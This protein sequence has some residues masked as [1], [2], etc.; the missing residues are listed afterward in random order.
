MTGE[1]TLL[2]KVLPIGGLKEKVLAAQREQMDCVI[3]PPSN[4]AAYLALPSAVKKRLKAHFISNYADAFEILFQGHSLK[5]PLTSPLT[6]VEN[7]QDLA[8]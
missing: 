5:S 7:H 6:S 8:G 2:G 3:L 4:K 1:I